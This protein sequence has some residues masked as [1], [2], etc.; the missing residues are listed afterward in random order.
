MPR[1]R[2]SAAALVERWRE[3]LLNLFFPPRCVN[4]RRVGES[5]CSVCRAQIEY[6]AGPVCRMCGSDVA[7]ADALCSHCAASPLAL[8]VRVAAYHEGALREAI[9]AF[10]YNK[11][12]ELAAG[13]AEMLA[14]AWARN[15]TQVDI[16]TAVP[17]H[18]E[19]EQMRGYNQAELVA[20]ALAP[21]LNVPYQTLL[22]RTRATADQIGLNARERRANV[23]DAF[24]A[25]GAR[26]ANRRVLIV[27]DVCT[28]GATLDACARALQAA[29]ARAVYGLT[30]A[31]PKHRELKSN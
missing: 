31:R 13:F 16:V 29:G 19:R 17:L 15:K 4:C 11:R 2:G 18:I 25:D 14:Q 26:A 27:D 12:T 30:V 7:R 28:T 9:H 22:Q 24:L 3:Q 21:R 23:T 5:F 1:Q 8:P 20:R 6:I 10:K